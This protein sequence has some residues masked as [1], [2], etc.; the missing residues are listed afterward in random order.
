MLCAYLWLI[1]LCAYP[2]LIMLCA[3]PLAYY[4]WCLPLAYLCVDSFGIEWHS[5]RRCC[6]DHSKPGP[7]YAGHCL[8]GQYLNWT[9]NRRWK[10]RD[11]LAD[12]RCGK[13][14]AGRGGRSERGVGGGA[15][16]VRGGAGSGAKEPGAGGT[17]LFL[18]TPDFM[19]SA[20]TVQGLSGGFP[21]FFPLSVTLAFLS[22]VIPLVHFT[23]SW[24]R[25][26]RR[27]KGSL[28][29]AAAAQTGNG[30]CHDLIGRMRVMNKQKKKLHM[31]V[32]T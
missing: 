28:Q 3:Y 9:K 4:A 30:L 21:L 16:G 20:G 13:A 12:E 10:I 1:M 26:G 7:R 24:D 15:A 18:P 19:A 2:W 6:D 17:P 5:S 32:L 23:S 31:Y 8:S 14:G 22:F 11:L 29:H 27:A 25:P